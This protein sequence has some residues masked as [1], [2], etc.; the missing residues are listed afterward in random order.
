MS[1]LRA[2]VLSIVVLCLSLAWTQPSFAAERWVTLKAE[3]E[4]RN[5]GTF[6]VKVQPGQGFSRSLQL[7]SKAHSARIKQLVIDYGNGQRDDV[8]EVELPAGQKT[9]VAERG[10]ADYLGVSSITLVLAQPTPA[11]LVL[12]VYGLQSAA[13]SLSP[14]ELLELLQNKG[15]D[16]Q[17]TS[18]KKKFAEVSVHYATTRKRGPDIEKY[19]RKIATYSAEHS[20]GLA[21]GRTI[22]TIPTTHSRGT[23]ER[24]LIDWVI[25]NYKAEDPTRH[26]TVA[27][28][29]E[30]RDLFLRGLR[31]QT[32]NAKLFKKQALLFIH[33]YNTSFEDAVFRAAQ[34]GYDIGFDGPILAFS[35]AARS[36]FLN[37]VRYGADLAAASAA[38]PALSE[39][40]NMLA[41]QSGIES[42]HIIAHSMGNVPTLEVLA[43]HGRKLQ[44]QSSLGNLKIRHVVFAAPDVSEHLFAQ[45]AKDLRGWTR[46][47]TLLTSTNDKAIVASRAYSDQPRAGGARCVDRAVLASTDYFLI[48]VSQAD[49]S[50]LGFNHSSFAER[51]HLITDIKLLLETGKQPPHERMPVYQRRGTPSNPCW[52]YLKN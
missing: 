16:P 21:L 45:Y 43:E 14:E 8:G 29:D 51:Q 47:V 10:P 6:I 39:F 24:P 23:I 30:G 40:L 36:G 5:A 48:D 7:I 13:K 4:Q 50:F 38:R 18:S 19:G 44:A 15:P 34:L 26:F 11:F 33:G 25:W 17:E 27:A 2:T 37:K 35:W 28:T 31:S 9:I 46:T 3:V 49:T 22:I 20:A 1:D 41:R 52:W 12:E 32:E 42:V